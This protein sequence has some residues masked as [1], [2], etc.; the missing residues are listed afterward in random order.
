METGIFLDKESG[1]GGGGGKKKKK[2]KKETKPLKYP[3]RIIIWNEH[4]GWPPGNEAKTLLHNNIK[5]AIA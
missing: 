3:H 4:F 2:K 1:G 5:A